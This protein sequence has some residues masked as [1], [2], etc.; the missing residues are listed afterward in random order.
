LLVFHGHGGTAADME[1]TTNFSSLADQQNFIAVYPQGIKDDDGLPMWASVGPA[2]DYG[3][4]DLTFVNNL[5][6][7][8]QKQLCVNPTRIY[9]TGFSNGGGMSHYL[10][11]RLAGRIAAVAP[12]A[13]NYFALPD[14]GCQ[15]SR[16]V[17][18]LAIHGT[19]DNVIPYNG[20]PDKDYPGWPLPAIPDYV[21]SWAS[22]NGCSKG[23]QIFLDTNE[24]KG[25]EWSGCR[26]NATVAHYQFKGGGHSYPDSIAG[27]P[28]S[29]V[30]WSFLY[31]HVL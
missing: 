2:A 14:G 11:C 12:I 8:I 26:D 25:E 27:R 5:L 18:L 3:I 16:A 20:R 6:N 9:A 22:R 4:D 29:E 23:P 21:A 19:A 7:Q 31:Q 17:A 15:P 30:I 10:A 13:G 24:I 28:G 1:T